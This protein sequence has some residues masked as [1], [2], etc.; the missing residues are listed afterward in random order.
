MS[1]R[2]QP[3]PTPLPPNVIAGQ[4]DVL[5]A[6]RRQVL[7]QVWVVSRNPRNSRHPVP[8][9]AMSTSKRRSRRER[10]TLDIGI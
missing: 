9:P 1:F 10:Q 6:Q 3:E 4:V 8:S 2:P 7:I 5:P